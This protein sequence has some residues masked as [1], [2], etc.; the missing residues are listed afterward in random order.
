MS[1]K[2]YDVV[3]IGAGFSG[4]VAA[5]DLSEQGHHVLVLE[6]RDRLGGRTWYRNFMGTEKPIEMGGGWISK[7]WMPAI[8]SEINRYDV[9]LVDQDDATEYAWVTGGEKRSNAPIPAEELGAAEHAIAALHQAMA[10]TP[11]GRLIPGEDYTDL[12]VPVT[13]WPPF[14]ALPTASREFVYAWAS[15]YSGSAPK[16]VSVMHF[17]LMMAAFGNEI[18]ALHFGLAQRFRDGTKVLVQAIADSFGGQIE[19][20]TR[21][22]KLLDSDGGVDV[23]TDK[24]TFR[25]RRV[26]CT[27]P[28]NSMPNLEFSPSLPPAAAGK[29]VKGTSSKSIKSWARCRN[30]PQGFM[31]VGW[32]TGMEWACN[33]YTLDDGTSLICS[34]AFDAGLVDPTDTASVQSALRKFIPEVEVLSVDS[35]DWVKDEFSQGTSMIVDPGW[36]VSGDCSAFSKPH[37]NVHFAGADHSL[38][39]TGWMEGAILSGTSVAGAVHQSLIVPDNGLPKPKIGVAQA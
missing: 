8:M 24:G 19:L 14:A 26:I 11:D 35:H 1:P 18:S 37:G 22:T 13:E 6:G 10:R 12:D 34:F 33:L 27:V 3:V 2:I 7:E 32:G 29:V 31:G 38:A 23:V 39:W 21:V 16:D 4:L 25:A 9:G 36:I 15:M 28:I 20:S 30:V 17:T 5:R